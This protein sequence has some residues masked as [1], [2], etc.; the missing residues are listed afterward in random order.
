MSIFRS[1]GRARDSCPKPLV[2]AEKLLMS[3]LAGENTC[4][5]ARIQ[6][7]PVNMV[8]QAFSLSGPFPR[9]ARGWLV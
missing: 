1:G 6:A 2:V 9:P 8:R 4:P 7:P 3:R 5:T